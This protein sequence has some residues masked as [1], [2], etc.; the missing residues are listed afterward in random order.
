MNS[1]HTYLSQATAT[2]VPGV[3]P[4]GVLARQA[5]ALAV[6]AASA[7]N[8]SRDSGAVADW[9]MYCII[10]AEAQQM[11]QADLD[12]LFLPIDRLPPV[13][14]DTPGLRQS[15]RTLV[16]RLSDL[17]TEAAAGDR[18]S[19]WRRLVWAMVAFRLEDASRELT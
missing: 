5:L 10:I 3:D 13:G 1:F 12:P 17:Y 6:H 15:V 11:L 9:D 19:P 7:A 4:D 18:G 14:P 2:L 16:R 8:C